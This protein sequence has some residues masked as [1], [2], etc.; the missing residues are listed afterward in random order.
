MQRYLGCPPHLFVAVLILLIRLT[1]AARSSWSPPPYGAVPAPPPGVVTGGPAANT[2]LVVKVALLQMAPSGNHNQTYNT[3]KAIQFC[4]KAAA[5]GADIA[6]MP[7]LWNVGYTVGYKGYDRNNPE[8]QKAWLAGSVKEDSDYVKTFRN[9][10]AKLNM[11]IGLTYMQTW[12]PLPRNVI[13]LIDRFGNILF[14]YAKLHTCDWLTSEGS[15][16]AGT[17]LYTAP[18]NTRC[19]NVTV[20]AMICYDREQPETARI[21]MLKGAEIILT[22][23]ACWLDPMRI[24][25]FRVRGFE[26][27]VYV[28]M[29]NYPHYIGPP[30][31][32]PYFNGNSSVF[33]FKGNPIVQAGMEEGIYMASLDITALR[34]DRLQSIEGDAFRKPERYSFLLTEQRE[35]SFQAQNAFQRPRPW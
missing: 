4:Q 33:D 19:G 20:G 31:L 34:K 17:E 9:L 1:S 2:S 11:A 21:L 23:N 6:L 29:T 32:G 26:N 13:S 10:A 16:M 24:M 15:T 35:P 14:T 28:A 30:P 27:D 8:A 22:P 5:Q 7:E 12:D 18:L 25:Q 3:L